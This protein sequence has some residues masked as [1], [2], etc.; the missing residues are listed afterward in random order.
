MQLEGLLW[1]AMPFML[2][3]IMDVCYPNIAD[4]WRSKRKDS[5]PL[6]DGQFFNFLKRCVR[7]APLQTLRS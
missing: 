5:S 7:A 3:V 2:I 1:F 4:L 6:I